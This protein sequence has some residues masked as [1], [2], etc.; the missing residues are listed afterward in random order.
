MA[1]PTTDTVYN[2]IARM[3]SGHVAVF[4]ECVD[5]TTSKN[6]ILNAMHPS[7]GLWVYRGVSRSSGGTL[8]MGFGFGDQRTCG[9]FPAGSFPVLRPRGARHADHTTIVSRRTDC[10]V[11]YKCGET[12]P[13]RECSWPDERF[14]STLGSMGWDRNNG[15]VELVPIV[16]GITRW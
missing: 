1:L 10:V 11:P 8:H 9:I 4:D 16:V 12:L 13:H 14:F 3:R 2:N 5:S 7:E 6:G 15:I